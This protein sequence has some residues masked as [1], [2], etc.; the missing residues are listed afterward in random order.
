MLERER[1]RLAVGARAQRVGVLDQLLER[2]RHRRRWRPGRSRGLAESSPA[3]ARQRE[4]AVHSGGRDRTTVSAA[5]PAV[6][7]TFAVVDA[8]YSRASPARRRRTRR[9]AERQR[10]R[11]PGRSRP[12]RR[13]STCTG[14]R[15]A[16]P[17]PSRISVR[18]RRAVGDVLQAEAPQLRV[19][20][21]DADGVRGAG[22][23]C[24]ALTRTA[25]TTPPAA[26]RGRREARQ[27]R[28]AGQRERPAERRL[29]RR[30]SARSPRPPSSPGWPRALAPIQYCRK[31]LDTC[32]QFSSWPIG[33]L[34]LRVRAA[35]RACPGSAR[36]GCRR[37][38]TTRPAARAGRRR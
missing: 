24:V 14:S 1:Q 31:S 27:E 3:A 38:P 30:S 21:R 11:R 25:G 12:R 13:W 9:R 10:Q 22:H 15:R 7:I 32:T 17:R 28:L 36:A 29:R 20:G 6:E 16:S 37:T 2:D 26:R 8:V 35:L 18:P 5:S 19:H 34:R 33:A 4:G 23:R